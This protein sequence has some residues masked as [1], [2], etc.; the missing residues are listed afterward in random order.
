MKGFSMKKICAWLCAVVIAFSGLAIVPE[1]EV[2]AQTYDQLSYITLDGNLSYS[3]VSNSI[4]GWANPWYGDG[5]ITFQFIYAGEP[6]N[7]NS[8][9][10][11]TI[12]GVA[13]SVGGGVVTEIASG[14][15]KLNPTKFTDNAYT[16]VEVTTTTGSAV[17]VFK[18]GTPTSA[19]DVT[20]SGAD[21]SQQETTKDGQ[22]STTQAG[23]Q[24]TT[25]VVSEQT[26]TKP[27]ATSLPKQV[28]G[29]VADSKV[30]D[31]AVSNAIFVAWADASNPGNLDI[32]DA[33]IISYTVYVYG[34]D[35]QL[36]TKIEKGVSGSVI[37]GFS[38]GTYQVC[39]AA[40]NSMGEG[41]PSAK[42]SVT[43]TGITMNYKYK[44]VCAGPK[45]PIGLSII[46]ANPVVQPSVGNETNAIEVAWASSSNAEASSYDTSVAGYNIYLF[47]KETGNP[48]RRVYVDGI[49]ESYTAI[50]SVS[51]GTYLVYIS[52][53]DAEGNE[54]SLSA[55]GISLPTE[56]TVKGEVY[57]NGQGFD[58]PNQPSLPVGLEIITAGI[59]YGFTVAWSADANLTGKQLNLYV[60]GV[61]IKVGIN[62]SGESSYYE[63]RLAAGTYTVEVKAQ[64]TSNFVESFSL[65]KDN[66]TIA[67]DPGLT[68]G[69]VEMLAD[70]LYKS[71][72]ETTT[73]ESTERPTETVSQNP[74]QG[75]SE[76]ASQNPT[77]TPSETVS[78]TPTEP[79]VTQA[80]TTNNSSQN[81]TTARPTL[82][83]STT[84]A[85]VVVPKVTVKKATKKK[86]AKMAKVTL[87]KVNNVT[88][89]QV[90]VCLN[91]NFKK[92]VKSRKFKKISFTF[93]GLKSKKVYYI[94]ARAYRIIKGKTY[95]GQWS[96]PKK[97]K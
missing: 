56:V 9:T 90:S 76:T 13:A 83:P 21:E 31:Y 19:G 36:V 27:A 20:S 43:V 25:T 29:V 18:K 94:R 26:T 40:V 55:P 84:T 69:T 70:P 81:P 75:P 54:S 22:Q 77:Q 48:Y 44:S 1:K 7:L 92:G 63:N 10:K 42:A 52:T 49:G 6:T 15:V 8:A 46:T 41:Q 16:T 87:K 37:G 97:I 71:Y 85:K 32:Y 50:K 12:N 64:Y 24:P 80:P 72:E 14:C 3:I 2:R 11:V 59:K 35:G 4:Q 28:A 17:V 82:D 68:T 74:T 89:Y 93:T 65:R 67:A 53:V 78:Q 88:G 62:K 23:Q 91:K 38:A 73:P 96:K 33:S 61:C 66:V 57:D 51:A 30:G 58:Y 34:S 39:V 5:G 95:Y 79:I 47:D 45:A 60:N 86:S